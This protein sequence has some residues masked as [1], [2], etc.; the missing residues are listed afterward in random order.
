MPDPTLDALVEA[1]KSPLAEWES[2]L[3]AYHYRK[4]VAAGDPYALD[5]IIEMS[6]RR[7]VTVAR[8]ALTDYVKRLEARYAS[9]NETCAAVIREADALRAEGEEY[10]VE[11]DRDGVESHEQ[12]EMF[13]RLGDD[14]QPGDRVRVT[15]VAKGGTE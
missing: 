1:L 6:M 7:R 4:M 9:L 11:E 10:V 12:G 8:A 5:H 2:T 14:Y 13:L 15:R 3:L